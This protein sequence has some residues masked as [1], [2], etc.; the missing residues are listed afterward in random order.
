MN[1]TCVHVTIE[2]NVPLSDWLAHCE[3]AVDKM[4]AIE[5]L[6]WKLWLADPVRQRAG[7]IYLFSDRRAAEAYVNGPIVAALRAMPQVR[8]VDVVTSGVAEELS[9]RSH[10]DRAFLAA[11]GQ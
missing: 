5:G 11:A 9:R 3:H 2:L 10:G 1:R 4:R 8:G 7:G 6:E